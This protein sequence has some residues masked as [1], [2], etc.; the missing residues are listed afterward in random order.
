MWV[1][2]WHFRLYFNLY[3]YINKRVRVVFELNIRDIY[4][5]LGHIRLTRRQRYYNK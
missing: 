4:Y 5:N 2:A 1:N 3:G